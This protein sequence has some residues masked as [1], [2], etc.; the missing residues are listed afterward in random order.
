M[1][2]TALVASKTIVVADDTA[3]VRDRFKAALEAAGH[4][5]ATAGN[6]VE[7]ATRVRS[8]SGHIDLVVLDLRLPQGRGVDL[9]RALRQIAG[10][11]ASIVVFSGTIASAH[12]VR[13]LAMLGVAGYVNEYTAV[14]HIVPSLA[15]HL[16]PDQRN[17][18]SNPRA[19]A[20]VAVS[21]RLGN[22][23]AAALTLNVSR[24]GLA[25]RTTSALDVGIAVKVRFRLTGTR[26]DID[27][28]ARVAW[29]DRRVGM[30][31]EFTRI[32]PRDQ[33][34]IEEFVQT[35]YFSNRKA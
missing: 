16:F 34:L 22:T 5:A 19:V 8:D 26:K 2:A 30:G 27:A 7:L 20:A 11:R 10:F 23:I 13:E 21:Y 18:R 1:P 9:V 3:F 24:G 14:Q 12:E 6:S 4:R 32:D 15:P 29:V 33:A 28:D 35:R 25:V 31:L 17:R